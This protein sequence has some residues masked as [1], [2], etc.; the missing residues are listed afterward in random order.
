ML[1]IFSNNL[2]Q[3]I[4]HLCIICEVKFIPAGS[5]VKKR[6]FSNNKSSAIIPTITVC[7]QNLDKAI[8]TDE[9][10]TF[11]GDSN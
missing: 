11:K 2:P 7:N 10:V 5:N 3:P 6:S 1:L 4:S 8:D 9:L